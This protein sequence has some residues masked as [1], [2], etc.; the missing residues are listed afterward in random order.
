MIDL[1]AALSD[2]LSHVSKDEARPLVSARAAYVARD[3][4]YEDP[5]NSAVAAQIA[6]TAILGLLNRGAS[7]PPTAVDLDRAQR[8]A[9][10]ITYRDWRFRSVP[11]ADGGVGIEVAATNPDTRDPQRTFATMRLAEVASSVEEACFRAALL[12]E[13]QEAQERFRVAGMA[14]FDPHSADN[15]AP[16]TNLRLGTAQ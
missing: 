10:S 3:D 13:H 1:S 14:V 2:A 7:E 5:S 12:V 16:P 11:M 4:L 9:G 6:V 8:I 15:V